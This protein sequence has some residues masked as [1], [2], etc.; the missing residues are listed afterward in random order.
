M[1]SAAQVLGEILERCWGAA[2]GMVRM[3]KGSRLR[4]K[5]TLYCWGA[6]LGML[7]VARGQQADG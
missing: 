6:A 4:A 1:T 3:A 7:R 5:V 2:L